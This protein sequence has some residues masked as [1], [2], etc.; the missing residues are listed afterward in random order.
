VYGHRI[1]SVL[2]YIVVYIFLIAVGIGVKSSTYLRAIRIN[3]RSYGVLGSKLLGEK[4]K[5]AIFVIFVYV[6]RIQ[7]DTHGRYV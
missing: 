3:N 2:P 6:T 1:L 4:D 5:Y 7:M